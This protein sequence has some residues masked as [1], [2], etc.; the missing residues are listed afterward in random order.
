MVV[1]SLKVLSILRLLFC[2]R[3]LDD[4]NDLSCDSVPLNSLVVDV[5][6]VGVDLANDE[7]KPGNEKEE[8]EYEAECKER[9]VAG[10]VS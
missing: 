10:L 8:E 1:L 3:R 6:L 4:E 7:E 2:C 9:G 5:C